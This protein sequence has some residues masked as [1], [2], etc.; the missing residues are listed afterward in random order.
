MFTLK[1]LCE[2]MKGMLGTMYV[3]SGKTI[4]MGSLQSV[5]KEIYEGIYKKFVSMKSLSI[6]QRERARSAQQ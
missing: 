1:P 5:P 4:R 6:L 3:K 2:G